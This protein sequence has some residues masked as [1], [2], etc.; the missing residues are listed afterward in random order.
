MDDPPVPPLEDDPVAMT[1]G[2][3]PDKPPEERL[4]DAILTNGESTKYRYQKCAELTCPCGCGK[5][6]KTWHAADCP[7]DCPF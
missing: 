1:L 4:L 2:L 3:V 6:V 5:V 7:D